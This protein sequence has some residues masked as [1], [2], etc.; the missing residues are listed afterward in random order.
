MQDNTNLKPVLLQKFGKVKESK[1]KN[2]LE[3]I[4]DCPFCGKKFKLYI[5]PTHGAF[6]CFSCGK[7]GSADELIGRSS[8]GPVIEPPPP[9][10]LPSNV[11]DPGELVPLT[12]VEED[13][14][15]ILYLR[16]RGFDPQELSER[17]GVRYCVTGRQFAGGLFDTTNTLIFPLWMNGELVGWQARLLYNPDNIDKDE[18]C[19]AM[20]FIKDEDDDWVKPPKYWT[21]PGVPKG[22]VLFNYD[23][24]R[25]S[26]AVVV[27]EGPFDAIAV[28]RCGVATLGKGITEQQG[29]NVKNYWKLAIM[30][31]D[32]GDADTE[33]NELWHGI[34]RSIITVPV[35]LQ[36]YKDA[37]EAPRAEIWNQIYDTAQTRGINLL[38]YKVIV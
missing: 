23:V 9:G 33:Q 28:G 24:A 1:G 26:D 21:A 16:Q 29:K 6:I 34:C 30:L 19:E 2:G 3:Y 25:Q 18:E 13:S 22:R 11:V 7:K 4:V 14:S 10:P 32:P 20:G 35:N 38:D 12:K 37:G 17:F 36:G 15:P 8:F 31:L 27:C 5:N